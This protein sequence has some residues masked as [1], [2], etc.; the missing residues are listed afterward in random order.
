MDNFRNVKVGDVVEFTYRNKK[1]EIK[2]RKVHV[3]SVR[4]VPDG[5]TYD[6][7]LEGYDE[8]ANREFRRFYESSVLKDVKPAAQPAPSTVYPNVVF[9]T[10]LIVDGQTTQ[11]KSDNYKADRNALQKLAAM[12]GWGGKTDD[13]S[14]SKPD[15]NQSVGLKWLND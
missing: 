15:N 12:F 2:E 14:P 6:L 10:N 1:N 13:I 5:N 4:P 8:N 7:V 3:E 11:V 9:T